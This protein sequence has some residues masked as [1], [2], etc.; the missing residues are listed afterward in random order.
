VP[1]GGSIPRW[2]QRTKGQWLAWIATRL[3]WVLD[4]FYVTLLLT[5]HSPDRRRCLTFWSREWRRSN[6]EFAPAYF[7]QRS[8]FHVRFNKGIALMAPKKLN[9]ECELDHIHPGSEPLTLLRAASPTPL[10]ACLHDLRRLGFTAPRDR[11]STPW[12]VSV[13]SAG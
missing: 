10:T 1:V 5:Y 4:A 11:G 8:F 12:A 2:K 3:R 13:L 6:R 7:G 9:P